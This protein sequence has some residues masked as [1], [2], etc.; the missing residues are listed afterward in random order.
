M[1]LILATLSGAIQTA[2]DKN[3][4]INI[5][6]VVFMNHCQHHHYNHQALVCT[7]NFN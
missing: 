5:I 3:R 1:Q 4:N 2:S 6:S 7:E